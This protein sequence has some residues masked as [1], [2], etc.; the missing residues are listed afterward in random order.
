MFWSA[1]GACGNSGLTRRPNELGDTIRSAAEF[2]SMRM[3]VC[4]VVCAVICAEPSF[5]PV[6]EHFAG[7][8][9]VAPI[10]AA[11]RNFTA[12]RGLSAKLSTVSKTGE[13][14]RGQHRRRP[15]DLTARVVFVF[16]F[17]FL[18]DR[19]PYH[20]AHL[21]TFRRPPQENAR[22]SRSHENAGR[23]LGH[24]RASRQGPSSPRGLTRRD[25]H[26]AFRVLR[27][28][29][30]PKASIVASGKHRSFAA[31]PSLSMCGMATLQAG[32]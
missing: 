1:I 31:A 29:R 22:L 9:S 24:S 18:A 10:A 14:A 16:N 8:G 15:G 2:Y 20:E 17:R 4:A 27:A 12:N 32:G 23:P 26:S 7:G 3:V 5:G 21:S 11:N 30:A 19:A 25:P 13:T 6:E 28:Y